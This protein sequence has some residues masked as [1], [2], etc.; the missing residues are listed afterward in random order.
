M[1]AY[2]QTWI[3]LIQVWSKLQKLNH[4]CLDGVRFFWTRLSFFKLNQNLLFRFLCLLNERQWPIP[5]YIW[6]WILPFD[7]VAFFWKIPFFFLVHVW[8]HNSKM[9]TNTNIEI[10]RYSLQTLSNLAHFRLMNIS[11]NPSYLYSLFYRNPENAV[12]LIVLCETTLIP[13]I[14]MQNRHYWFWNNSRQILSDDRQ[15]ATKMSLTRERLLATHFKS[16]QLF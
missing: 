12:N 15:G 10:L 13:Y 5:L 1:Y 8:K 16:S 7:I 3:K 14:R 6:S 11:L 9:A 2:Y 4:T